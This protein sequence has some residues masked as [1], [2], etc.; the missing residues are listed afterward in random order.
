MTPFSLM[1]I[2]A[3]CPPSHL[4]VETASWLGRSNTALGQPLAPCRLEPD[5]VQSACALADHLDGRPSW[6]S[7]ATTFNQPGI[8]SNPGST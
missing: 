3:W 5:I 1:Q 6:Q 2:S 7:Q 4:I 8:V